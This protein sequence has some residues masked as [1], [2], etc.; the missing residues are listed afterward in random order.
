MGSYQKYP[1]KKDDSSRKNRKFER[2]KVWA[3]NKAERGRKRK[4]KKE[5]G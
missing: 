1:T 5:N 2:Q 3:H 4:E